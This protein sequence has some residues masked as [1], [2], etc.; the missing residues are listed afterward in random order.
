M[1]NFVNLRFEKSRQLRNSAI[2]DV[3][4]I[5]QGLV[6]IFAAQGPILWML[7]I[8]ACLRPIF[9]QEGATYSPRATSGPQR[10][11]F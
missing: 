4:T 9:L 7:I 6:F 5:R 11:I 10:Q 8:K 2:E 1:L 3:K